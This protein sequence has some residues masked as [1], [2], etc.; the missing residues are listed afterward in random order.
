MARVQGP[1]KVKLARDFLFAWR[2][3]ANGVTHQTSKTQQKY[4]EHWCSYTHACKSSPDLQQE[5]TLHKAILLTGFAARVR[6]GA[7][8]LGYEVKVQT[9]SDAMAAISAS[10]ELGGKRSPALK[11]E[12]EF[13]T[14]LKRCL[15]GFRGDDP[16]AIPQ[17]AVPV[18]LIN[19]ISTTAFSTS[20]P[21]TQA[22]ASLIT[23]AF[24]YLLRVGE[25]TSP[26]RVKVNGK[27]KAATRTRQFR[28]QDV[29]FFKEGK[30]LTRKSPLATLLTADSATL[31]ISNQKNGKMGQTIHHESTGSTG[32]VAALAHRVH[33]ILA[34][35]GK[36]SM[37][38][39]MVHHNDTWTPV[40][41]TTINSTLRSHAKTLKLQAQGIDPDI[42]G[43]HSLRAGGA[44]A[45]KLQDYP[46][47]T[48]QKMGRWSSSTWLQY[49]HTQIAHI[50]KGVASKM[51]EELPFLNIGFIEPPTSLT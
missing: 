9:V 6:T 49:I 36:E 43:S 38:L 13:I 14:P 35:G 19:H 32:A 12:G 17:L 10:L 21:L 28:V 16:P 11:A 40:S 8:G 41:S 37:L 24:Y 48:I 22:T 31:K 46:D 45:L 5:S 2:A 3:I 39:C 47:T 33:H 23:I 50:S 51:S 25:Y 18:K 42:I 4:W 1:E 20:N 30:V 26:R 7:L 15:E 44:M 34:N 29:G 27:W